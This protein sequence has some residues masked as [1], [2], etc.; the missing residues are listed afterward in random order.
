VVKWFIIAS[1]LFVWPSKIAQYPLR[2]AIHLKGKAEHMFDSRLDTLFNPINKA[3]IHL[4]WDYCAM[5]QT[6][7]RKRKEEEKRREGLHATRRAS[8]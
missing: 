2:P 1:A 8:E 3:K 4:L 5:E 7:K 6:V